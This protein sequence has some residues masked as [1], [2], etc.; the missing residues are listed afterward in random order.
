MSFQLFAESMPAA[1]SATTLATSSEEGTTRTLWRVTCNPDNALVTVMY[2]WMRLKL[3]KSYR[4]WSVKAVQR[5]QTNYPT[6]LMHILPW[7]KVTITIRTTP[8]INPLKN[9]S[10]TQQSV[11]VLY[12][13]QFPSK[14]KSL[15]NILKTRIMLLMIGIVISHFLFVALKKKDFHSQPREYLDAWHNCS[16][17]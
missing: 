13:A 1:A 5:K 4:Y 14:I 16:R 9:L 2:Q 12:A 10:S 6:D 11:T 15:L 3:S 8:V 17:S 7:V